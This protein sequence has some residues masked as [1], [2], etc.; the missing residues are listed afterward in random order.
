MK[1]LVF[2][3]WV[4]IKRGQNYVAS[5]A[6]LNNDNTYYNVLIQNMAMFK[7]FDSTK[8]EKDEK[9]VSHKEM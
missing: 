5:S 6:F 9:P 7:I 1:S 8:T 3:K 4:F 2:I